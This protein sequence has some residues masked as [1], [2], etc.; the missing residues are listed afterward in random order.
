[1]QALSRYREFAADRGA[2][3][4]TGRPSALASALLKISGVD[5][6][7]PDAGPARGRR[8]ERVLHRPRVGART[9]SP[10]CSPRTRRWRSASRRCRASR[11]SCRA[12]APRRSPRRWASSTR[13]SGSARSR[14]AARPAV[15]ASPPRTS[16][17]ETTHGITHARRGRDRLPAAGH[18]RLRADRRATIEEVVRGTGAGDRHDASRPSDDEFGYR[19]MIL[20]DAD[21]EDLVGRRQR[22]QR[23][24]RR[25]AATATACCARCSPSRTPTAARS[26]SSTT[27]S[28]ARW[29]PFVPGRGRAAAQHRARAAAQGA[30]GA[31]LPIEPELER[32]FPLWGIPI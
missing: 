15:R 29:Y 18:R 28:A 6:R 2:A 13:C 30:V 8:D 9:R 5:E 32:W 12:G 20:R 27:T 4:I 26:T 3:V 7:I 19:W 22:G 10:A 16:T 11:R 24:A 31:E 14:P 17:L 25:S 23:R 1:M 21:V